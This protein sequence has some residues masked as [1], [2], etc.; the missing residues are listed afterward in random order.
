[1]GRA[2]RAEARQLK[3]ETDRQRRE[4]AREQRRLEKEAKEVKDTRQR[5]RYYLYL[6]CLFDVGSRI[7]QYGYANRRC[8]ERS[9]SD[10][11]LCATKYE[12]F[13]IILF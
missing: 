13:G 6:H 7:L 3:E 9:S 10:P 8:R 4:E 2:R 12:R 5:G 1:M 11:H